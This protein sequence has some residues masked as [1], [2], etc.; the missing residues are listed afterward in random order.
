MCYK[1][2]EQINQRINVEKTF[3]DFKTESELFEFHEIQHFE[4]NLNELALFSDKYKNKQ[5]KRELS[6]LLDSLQSVKVR[7]GIFKQDKNLGEIHAIKTMSLLRNYT[8][9]RNSM[10]VTFQMEPEILLGWVHKTKPFSKMY[11]KIQTK[12]N[13]T[14]SKILY[15]ICKDYENQKTVTRPFE[16]WLKVLGFSNDLFAT[17][18]VSQLKQAYLNKAV[19]E[20]NEH[21]DIFIKLIT[22]KKTKGEVSMT[23]DFEKQS[24]A[25]IENNTDENVTK[26]KFYSKSESKLNALV[27]NGYKVF[28][29]ELWIKADIKKNESKYESENRIDIWLQETDEEDKKEIYQLLAEMI[30]GCDDPMVIIDNYVIKGIFTKDSFTTNASETIELLNSVI[31]E[32]NNV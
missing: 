23:V 21:T 29:T 20:I 13:L 16:E 19:N 18:T 28:D 8:K 27:K 5:D 2:R 14:Y 32:C 31:K 9:I 3:S 24:C 12:L 1:A 6:N 11:L 10:K 7:V 17:K 15:E 30:D 26:H 22:G 4:I 25:L